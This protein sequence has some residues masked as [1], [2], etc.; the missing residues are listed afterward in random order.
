MHPEF[1]LRYV[2]DAA[3][4]F[5][6][7]LHITLNAW[8]LLINICFH[9][10]DPQESANRTITASQLLVPGNFLKCHRRIERVRS[11]KF[12]DEFQGPVPRCLTT[13]ASQSKRLS[14]EFLH[15]AAG[16]FVRQLAGGD[17]IERRGFHR[18]SLSIL[19]FPSPFPSLVRCDTPTS[20]LATVHPAGEEMKSRPERDSCD[21]CPVIRSTLRRE[22]CRLE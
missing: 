5:S 1:L 4:P 3:R 19:S 17:A 11:Q 12:P 6:R 9:P 13:H 7:I 2:D 22:S 14:S 8:K 21:V 18:S 20:P 16:R 15:E 10:Q